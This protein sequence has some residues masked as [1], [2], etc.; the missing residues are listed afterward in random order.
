MKQKIKFKFGY[1]RDKWKT[2]QTEKGKLHSQKF[3]AI[4]FVVFI[5]SDSRVR[6]FRQV[7]I[8]YWGELLKELYRTDTQLTHK[9]KLHWITQVLCRFVRREFRFLMQ[10]TLFLITKQSREI[11]TYLENIGLFWDRKFL[12]V[13][14]VLILSS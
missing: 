13:N 5:I 3:V 7:Q 9:G 1:Q 10:F 12:K 14:F 2:W 6:L 4:S 11:L 8:I